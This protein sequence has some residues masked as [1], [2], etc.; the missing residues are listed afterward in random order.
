MHRLGLHLDRYKQNLFKTLIVPTNMPTLH[1]FHVQNLECTKM[2]KYPPWTLTNYISRC[3]RG[4]AHEARSLHQ[5]SG[6][7]SCSLS[8]FLEGSASR[9][10]TLTPITSCPFRAETGKVKSRT[11][12]IH[13]T[14]TST[15]GQFD[16]RGVAG[17]VLTTSSLI[18]LK[19]LVLKFFLDLS[20][21]ELISLN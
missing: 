1:V 9:T 15:K 7:R 16:R 17:A 3:E 18:K 12:D 4:K 11:Q 8:M 6:L 5:A 19:V 14:G 13:F 2:E 10:F 20:T 21:V